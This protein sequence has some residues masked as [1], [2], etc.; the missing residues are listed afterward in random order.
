VT[1]IA[2]W[3]RVITRSLG[4]PCEGALFGIEQVE[5]NGDERPT[6]LTLNRTPA[7]RQP[8]PV[9]DRCV[10]LTMKAQELALE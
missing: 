8:R 6:L 1:A 2:G 9:R 3:G 4:N 10:Q 7:P 5:R